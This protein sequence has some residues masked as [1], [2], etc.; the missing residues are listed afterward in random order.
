MDI[1]ATNVSDV[2]RAHARFSQF[3]GFNGHIVVRVYDG[4][5]VYRVYTV[6]DSDGKMTVK[7]ISKEYKSK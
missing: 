5:S 1:Y 4:G 6:S 2:Q 7:K 3:K